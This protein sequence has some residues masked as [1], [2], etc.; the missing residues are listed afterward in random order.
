MDAHGARVLSERIAQQQHW[1]QADA[2]RDGR[3]PAAD[4]DLELLQD[5]GDGYRIYRAA[6]GNGTSGITTRERLTK[7]L[8][9]GCWVADLLPPAPA[10]HA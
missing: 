3:Q 2:V 8:V 1:E 9:D 7:T 6:R 5:F 4:P 10:R